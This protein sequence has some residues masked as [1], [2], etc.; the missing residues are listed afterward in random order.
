M[1]LTLL[2]LPSFFCLVLQ[3]E[4]P[5]TKNLNRTLCCPWHKGSLPH[6]TESD[7]RY[8]SFPS[9]ALGAEGR[10]LESETEARSD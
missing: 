10:Q 2:S 3:H 8:Y 9:I 7:M 1:E 4:L 6:A 5:L